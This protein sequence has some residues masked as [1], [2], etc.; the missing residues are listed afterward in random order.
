MS[1]PLV[2]IK[3]SDINTELG[4]APNTANTSLKTRSEQI[5]WQEPYGMSELRG[6]TAVQ[7]GVGAITVIT[8]TASAY[9]AY[10]TVT[11]TGLAVDASIRISI[12]C[13]GTKAAGPA[14]YI[15]W[16]YSINSTSSWTSL[17][18]LLAGDV[19]YSQI[20]EIPVDLVGQTLRIRVLM[21]FLDGVTDLTKADV[22]SGRYT[23]IT[24]GTGWI[25]A[26]PI[27]SWTKSIPPL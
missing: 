4:Y 18:S 10:R 22:E 8:D 11:Y 19:T 13:E 20:N 7:L 21:G 25:K 3:F 9:E 1:L 2:D 24:E 17:A 14:N 26:A 23:H 15:R 5:G 6:F 16:Y 27:T 12:N